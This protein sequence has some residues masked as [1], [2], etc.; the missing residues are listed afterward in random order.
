MNITNILNIDINLLK[1]LYLVMETG[2]VVGAAKKANLSQSAVSHSLNKLRD[3]LGDPLLIREGQKL[4]PTPRAIKIFNQLP[5][6]FEEIE[7]IYIQKDF[8]PHESRQTM[9]F[10]ITDFLIPYFTPLVTGQLKEKAPLLKYS[11]HSTNKDLYENI[12]SGKSDFAVGAIL[13]PPKYIIRKKLSDETFSCLV[14]KSIFNKKKMSIEEYL[15]FTHIG[16]ELGNNVQHPVDNFLS[17]KNVGKRNVSITVDSFLSI[18]A[19]ISAT[20]YIA[21]IPTSMAKSITK[22]NTELQ[23]IALPFIKT[24]FPIYISWHEKNNY[25]DLH[26][27]I[28]DEIIKNYQS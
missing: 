24:T 6:I 22:S 13:N 15:S 1:S 28:K 27:W 20:N 17:K 12:S 9:T 14:S 19:I 16:Y 3:Q 11:F 10:Q 5:S 7:R 8:I 25:S 18:P 2:S 23:S 26:R 4:Q 21:T